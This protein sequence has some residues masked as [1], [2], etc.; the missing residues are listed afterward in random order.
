MLYIKVWPEKHFLALYSLIPLVIQQEF[1][2]R[3][4]C[5]K[6][7]LVLFL[8]REIAVH[9]TQKSF[10]WWS[11]HSHPRTPVWL[12]FLSILYSRNLKTTQLV[13][14]KASK[15]SVT[16]DKDRP[17]ALPG[18]PL[19]RKNG[20][21]V[22]QSCVCICA[23]CPRVDH[24]ALNVVWFHLLCIQKRCQSDFFAK[25]KNMDICRRL[26]GFLVVWKM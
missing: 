4:L 22:G 10:A 1:T 2:H 18:F 3:P 15:N 5:A 6:H 21:R 11:T 14:G 23:Q 13:S 16:L 12:G 7:R 25:V 19:Y 26:M 24:R 9:R 20:D 8:H 17:S